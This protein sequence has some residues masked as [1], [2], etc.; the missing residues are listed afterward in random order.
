M[1]SNDDQLEELIATA[2]EL[3]DRVSV[4]PDPSGGFLLNV[5]VD[6]APWTVEVYKSETHS[7]K[8]LRYMNE[9]RLEVAKARL[10]SFL[11][12]LLVDGKIKGI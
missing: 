12:K 4:S 10:E 8:T 1:T 5:K 11:A 7:E 9:T 2:T 6:G 3:A